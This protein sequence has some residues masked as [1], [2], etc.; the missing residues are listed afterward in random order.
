MKK[1]NKFKKWELLT[2]SYDELKKN[3]SFKNVI[4]VTKKLLDVVAPLIL[5]KIFQLIID[6][7][8]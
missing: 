2:L 6:Y 3:K 4:I 7:F 1:K 8:F 5:E